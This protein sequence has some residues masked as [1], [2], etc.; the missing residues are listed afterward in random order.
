NAR[1]EEAEAHDEQAL[2]NEE[3]PFRLAPADGVEELV[4]R[5]RTERDEEGDRPAKADRE[6]GPVTRVAVGPVHH[7][8]TPEIHEAEQGEN[9][10]VRNQE[11][12]VEQG[13]DESDPEPGEGEQ[14]ADPADDGE[15][16]GPDGLVRL[17][18]KERQLKA[19]AETSPRHA[20]EQTAR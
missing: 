2:R 1:V 12:F 4:H 13:Q 15:R 9:A 14:S 10:T 5:P 11:W 17:V 7:D 19:K 8:V 6:T 18:A 20:N 3:V 16:P